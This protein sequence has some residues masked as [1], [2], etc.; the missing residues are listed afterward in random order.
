MIKAKEANI[1][2]KVTIENLAKEFIWNE[3]SSKVQSAID[4]GWFHTNVS[5]NKVPNAQYVGPVVVN[6]L[7]DEYGYE[8]E[9]IYEDHYPQEA[10]YICIDWN[11]AK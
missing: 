4:G 8:A 2:S 1:N 5:L 7:K 10:S 3:V 11:N 9:F 6:M